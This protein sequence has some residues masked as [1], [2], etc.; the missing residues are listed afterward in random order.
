MDRVLKSLLLKAD[1]NIIQK[2]GGWS[3]SKEK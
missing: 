2:N 1:M 3:N